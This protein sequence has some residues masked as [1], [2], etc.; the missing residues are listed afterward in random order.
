MTERDLA[1]N[2]HDANETGEEAADALAALRAET[3]VLKDQA[4]RYA[5][6]AG[7]HSSAR[8]ARDQ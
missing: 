2:G 7:E 5:A 4:L 6:E 1:E 8:R 3:E